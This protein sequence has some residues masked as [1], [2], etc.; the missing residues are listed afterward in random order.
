MLP[1]HIQTPPAV[2]MIG[3]ARHQIH[4]AHPAQFPGVDGVAVARAAEMD[5]LLPDNARGKHD[6]LFHEPPVMGIDV[7]FEPG[8]FFAEEG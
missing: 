2:R 5:S 6:F 7:A 4:H 1:V 3:H 8:E